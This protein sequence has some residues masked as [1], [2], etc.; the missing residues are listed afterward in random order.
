MFVCFGLSFNLCGMIVGRIS[1]VCRCNLVNFWNIKVNIRI[2]FFLVSFKM[3]IVLIVIVLLIYLFG[4]I[5]K[6]R[7]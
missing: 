6:L 7:V 4:E 1:F 3:L 2:N 5:K